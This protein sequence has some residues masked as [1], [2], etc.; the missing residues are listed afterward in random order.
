VISYPGN[1]VYKGIMTDSRLIYK[2]P[3]NKYPMILELNERGVIE[4]TALDE[5]FQKQEAE[6]IVEL[7][8]IQ[9][10]KALHS[11]EIA[12]KKYPFL[13]E[14]LR[15]IGP[16]NNTLNTFI[17]RKLGSEQDLP[18]NAMGKDYI[19]SGLKWIYQPAHESFTVSFS[20]YMAAIFSKEK[21]RF[22]VL[23]LS[24][25]YDWHNEVVYLPGFGDLRM[26]DLKEFFKLNNEK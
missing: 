20:G 17:L 4:R 12:L 10:E 6:L 26:N 21:I 5:P 22:S 14:E 13:E 9:A 19:G 7:S 23:G 24:L 18:S 8:G 1:G 25:G 3:I 11:I 15:L 16:N 2:T